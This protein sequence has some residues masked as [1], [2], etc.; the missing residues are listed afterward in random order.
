MR[1][2]KIA[3]YAILILGVLVIRSSFFPYLRLP[4]VPDLLLVLSVLVG[5]AAGSREGALVG[6]GIGLTRD[7][8]AGR[9]LGLFTLAAMAMGFLAGQVTRRIYRDFV[10]T[11]VL[12][13]VAGT[14]LQ[15]GLLVS[16]LV[17]GGDAAGAASWHNGLMVALVANGMAGGILFGSVMRL[18]AWFYHLPDSDKPGLRWGWPVA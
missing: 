3:S 17:I 5:L 18:Q 12:A 8:L 13:C 4:F 15:R 6:L 7:L 9:Y 1:R 2:R 16:A 10:L 11:P 14:L